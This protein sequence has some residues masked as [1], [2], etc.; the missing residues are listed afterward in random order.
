[1]WAVTATSTVGSS[2]NIQYGKLL[3][4]VLL[5]I[6]VLP[7]VVANEP[8]ASPST[9]ESPVGEHKSGK[10]QSKVASSSDDAMR[11][12]GQTM[13][14]ALQ[15]NDI[16]MFRRCWL[17]E[18]DMDKVFES[19]TTSSR[20]FSKE[21]RAMMKEHAHKLKDVVTAMFPLLRRA[22]VRTY[23]DL[24]KIS[25][26]SIAATGKD[27]GETTLVSSFIITFSSSN[28]VKV[29]YVIDDGFYVNN[30]W[31]FTDQ[32]TPYI[33]VITNDRTRKVFLTTF[34]TKAERDL[35]DSLPKTAQGN[36][37]GIKGVGEE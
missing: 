36:R 23:G 35:F 28:E 6:L 2:M 5:V 16:K 26:E 13:L 10:E 19:S 33:K 31:Y 32:P 22:L 8:T 18:D 9:E 37:V 17:L 11:M 21:Y 24:S 7:P 14:C 25:L 15:K 34:A 27:V 4:A 3:L 12:L 20:T 29:V 1:M 30:R